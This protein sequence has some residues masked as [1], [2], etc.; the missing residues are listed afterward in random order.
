MNS[1]PNANEIRGY[2]FWCGMKNIKVYH[3]ENG[4][5]AHARKQIKK[6][7]PLISQN[8]AGLG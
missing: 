3:A 1:H 6:G 4:V 5:E 7:V 8:L 2:L